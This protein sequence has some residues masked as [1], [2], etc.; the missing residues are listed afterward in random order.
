LKAPTPAALAKVALDVLCNQ[1]LGLKKQQENINSKNSY[2]K[3]NLLVRFNR[4]GSDKP[5]TPGT[6][7]QKNIAIKS[8]S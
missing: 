4:N 1:Y 3:I 5:D 8:N 2:N 6:S 7:S